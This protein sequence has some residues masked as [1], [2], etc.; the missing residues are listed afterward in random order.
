MENASDRA[1]ATMILRDSP[2]P[3]SPPG[4]AGA[5]EPHALGRVIDEPAPAAVT[6]DELTGRIKALCEIRHPLRRMREE[7]DRLRQRDAELTSDARQFDEQL[8]L[9]RQIQNDLLPAPLRDTGPLSISTLYLP[10]DRVS[11]RPRWG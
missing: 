2:T 8:Q 4:I 1:C 3:G 11:G 7:L 9:A 5:A 6:A 10:A